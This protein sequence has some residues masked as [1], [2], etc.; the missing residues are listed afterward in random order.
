MKTSVATNPLHPWRR[1]DGNTSR[2]SN[3]SIRGLYV[4]Y[5][6]VTVSSSIY[7]IHTMQ[8]SP[9]RDLS[10]HH[11]VDRIP[12]SHKIGEKKYFIPAYKIWLKIKRKKS[13]NSTTK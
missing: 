3:S 13:E 4:V 11:S 12:V 2:N 5:C 6:M 7:I 10:R 1:P 9:H 8:S